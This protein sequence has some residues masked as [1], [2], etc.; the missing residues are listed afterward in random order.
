MKSENMIIE[1][2]VDEIILKLK[3]YF[4]EDSNV[5]FAFIFGSYVK[6]RQKRGS[7][8]DVAVF[9]KNPPEGLDLLG[10]TNKLS[11]I[12]EKEV[13]L[14]VLNNAPPLL[15][16]QIVKYGIR[17]IKKD[18]SLYTRFREKTM[19][20]YEEYKNVSGMNIYD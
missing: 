10:Y 9:F 1:S 3:A 18:E 7:D 20:D 14:V 15:R 5:Q 11:D 13:H 12:L 2:Q 19:T 4:Q 6:G 17:L 16:H 8:L